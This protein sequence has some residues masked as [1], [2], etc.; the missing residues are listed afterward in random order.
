MVLGPPS[1]LK[2]FDGKFTPVE[3]KS[4][5]TIATPL[6]KET[7]DVVRLNDAGCDPQGRFLVG[8]MNLDL[9]KTSTWH[10]EVYRYAMSRI[11]LAERELN[12]R[13]SAD[14]TTEKIFED[15][16]VSNGIGFSP[17]GKT[18]RASFTSAGTRGDS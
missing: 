9:G 10:G 12:S 8:S 4:I 7:L 5:K 1:E 15:I 16:G 17:D 6:R 18:F 3:R 14:G 11:R 2:P 13:V